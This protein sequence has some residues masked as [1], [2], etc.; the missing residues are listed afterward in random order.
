GPDGPC[1]SRVPVPVT[2]TLVCPKAYTNGEKFMHSMPCH[3]LNT[4]GYLCVSVLNLTVPRTCRSTLDSRVTAP[5]RKDFPAGTTTCPPPALLHAAIARANA[6]LSSVRPSP[7]AP[8]AVTS[9]VRS[10]NVGGLIR[11]RII[12]TW[13]QGEAAR[14]AGVPVAAP[15]DRAINPAVPAPAATTPPAT[16]RLRRV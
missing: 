12:G 7:L 6:A 3:R 15:A 11:P 8:K 4:S 9:K 5:V 13:S 2:A 16:S 1:P 10:G 14:A